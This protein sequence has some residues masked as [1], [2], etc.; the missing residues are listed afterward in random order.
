MCSSCFS[1]NQGCLDGGIVG[2]APPIFSN[3]QESSS[4]VSQAARGLA[5]V[6]SVTFFSSNNLVTIVGQLVR[7]PPANRCLGTSML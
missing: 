7:P 5:T 3:L 2:I 1:L 6:Y 4:K